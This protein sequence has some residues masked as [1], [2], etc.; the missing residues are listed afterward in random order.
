MNCPKCG[1]ENIQTIGTTCEEAR[2]DGSFKTA[3][4][5]DG[6]HYGEIGHHYVGHECEACGYVDADV[7]VHD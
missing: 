3:T 1:S 4:Y 5:S 7:C 6:G 2:A